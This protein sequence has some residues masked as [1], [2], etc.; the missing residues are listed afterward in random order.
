MTGGRGDKAATVS[1]RKR[2]LQ[3]HPD[4]TMHAA[5]AD[6]HCYIFSKV[7]RCAVQLI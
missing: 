3:A 4:F 2:L 5:L 7:L 1:V 6:A